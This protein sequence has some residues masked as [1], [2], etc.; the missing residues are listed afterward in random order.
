M[1]LSFL[2]FWGLGILTF[3]GKFPYLSGLVF[4]RL[5][6]SNCYVLGVKDSYV[7]GLVFL[8]LGVTD[9]YVWRLVITTFGG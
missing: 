7:W 5:R 6:V 3:G 8:P 4:F 1:W 2:T 9:S